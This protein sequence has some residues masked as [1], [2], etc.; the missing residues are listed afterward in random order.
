LELK[1]GRGTSALHSGADPFVRNLKGYTPLHLAAITEKVHTL[2]ALLES[3]EALK[4]IDLPDCEGATA[5]H[6]A[7]A[8]PI[9]TL[10]RPY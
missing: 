3:S 9:E 5:L 1:P 2:N 7:R 10:L 6:W 4:T 8:H